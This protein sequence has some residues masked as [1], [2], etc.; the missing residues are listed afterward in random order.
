MIAWRSFP[1]KRR[2]RRNGMIRIK[3][4]YEKPDPSDGVRI[5]V[6][7]LWPRGMSKDSARI[8][9]WRKD[10]AP[11]HVLREWVHHDPHRWEEF[12][13]RYRN[14]LNATGKTEE[15]KELADRARMETVTLLYAAHDVIHNNAVALKKIIEEISHP[16]GPV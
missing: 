5:L 9:A 10:L 15:L 7:R 12:Q 4:I 14:E 1:G 6:D 2:G 3:R 8:D 13:V 16:P 11:T